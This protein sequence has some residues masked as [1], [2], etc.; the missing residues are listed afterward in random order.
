MKTRFSLPLAALCSLIGAAPLQAQSTAFTYQGRL[1]SGGSPATG[2]FDF[3]FTLFAT[4]TS[5]TPRGGPLAMNAVGVTNGVFT[6][7]LDFG[8]EAFVFPDR[9]LEIAV[10]PANNGTFSTLTPRQPITPTP[11]AMTAFN[12]PGISGSSLNS[13]AGGPLN[14]VVV[15]GMG[16]VGVGTTSPVSRLHVVSKP[17]DALPPRVESTSDNRFNAGL[18]FAHGT[19]GKGYVG[20]PDTG[21]PFAAN[22]LVLFSAPGVPVSLWPGQNRTLSAQPNGNIGIGT[23]TPQAKLEVRGDVRLGPNGQFKAASGVENFYIVRGTIDESGTIL[24]GA[25]FQVQRFGDGTYKITFDTPFAT[26]PTITAVVDYASYDGSDG[27]IAMLVG[28]PTTSRAT[29]RVSS[30]GGTGRNADFNFIAIGPR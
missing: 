1:T 15:D 29:V 2:S 27:A 16:K 26:A 22:E 19:T 23:T 18:D 8:A 30:P 24:D 3:Q 25:G 4:A 13:S 7:P 20:V 12:V 6:V 11:Y 9:W 28:R 10:C 14:A 21:A 5:S 17:D